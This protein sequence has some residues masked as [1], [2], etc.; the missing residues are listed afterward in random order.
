MKPLEE[1][2]LRR[3]AKKQARKFYKKDDILFFNNQKR[4]MI[5]IDEHNKLFILKD[6]FLDEVGALPSGE[7][8]LLELRLSTA[9]VARVLEMEDFVLNIEKRFLESRF[10]YSPK[11]KRKMFYSGQSNLYFI[12]ELKDKE[13]NYLIHPFKNFDTIFFGEELENVDAITSALALELGML[14]YDPIV[15]KLL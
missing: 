7:A 2:L 5:C 12:L 10:L 3:F 11:A 15:S 13:Q 9:E 14:Q 8:R 1:L 6:G 4:F